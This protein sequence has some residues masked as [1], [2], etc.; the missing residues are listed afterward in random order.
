VY[1]ALHQ[2]VTCR[3]NDIVVHRADGRKIPLITWAAPIELSNTGSPDA[4]VWVLEDW[5]AMQQAEVAL[6]ESELRLRAIIEAM[7]EGVVVQ[8]DTGTV[9]DCNAAACG[10]LSA[11]RNQVIGRS[12]LVPE[13]K[14]VKEDGAP[15]A[16]ADQPYVRAL[17]DHQPARGVILGIRRDANDE[18]RWLLVNAMPLPVGVAVG[19][20]PQ[21]ARVV[22][23]FADITE[24]V[25]TQDTLRLTKDRYQNLVETLPFML[26]QRDASFKITY[27]NPAASAL[28]GHSIEELMQPGFC[29]SIIHPDDEPQYQRA[30]QT[31]AE[32]RSTRV[33]GRFQAKDGSFKSVLAF[34]HPNLQHGEVIGST[35]LVVDITMQ[36]RLEEELRHSQHLELIGRL[37][38]GIVHDFNHWLTVMVGFAGCAKA[39]LT[40]AHAAWPYLSRIEDSGAQAAHLAGQL[41]T[42]SKQRPRQVQPVDLNAVVVQTLK[43]AK[44]VM[45]ARIDVET[46]LAP[47]LPMACGDENQFKQIVMNLCLNARDAMPDGGAL[48]IRTCVD[49]PPAHP[50]ADARNAWVHLSIQDSGVGMPEDVRSRVFEPFFSTKENGTGLG[51][52]VVQQIV[53]ESG[54]IIE[55]WSKPDE[56]TRFDIWLAQAISS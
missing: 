14:C 36:R 22:T 39:E 20:N 32:G 11:P 2:G 9:I 28:T 13:S 6:R 33:E 5:T 8:D 26:V 41:L 46:A 4:A 55:V 47:E 7:G 51:L 27:L 53:K 54:G 38:S 16:R 23:T 25:K 31:V 50:A 34:L 30:M 10:I 24:Q 37:A 35:S 15:F 40:S 3:A 52:S 21:K 43:L 19:L 48:T 17:R 49:A 1:K 42:F 18:V 29:E 56:G 12:A 44:S 45:P